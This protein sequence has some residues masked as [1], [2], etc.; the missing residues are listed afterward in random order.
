[1]D[2]A[3]LWLVAVLASS[4]PPLLA[5]SCLFLLFLLDL[6]S[7]CLWLLFCFGCFLLLFFFFFNRSSKSRFSS[8]AIFC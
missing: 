6:A 3:S 8:L 7:S 2:V 4:L 5:S 1:M